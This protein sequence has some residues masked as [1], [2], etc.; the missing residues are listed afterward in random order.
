MRAG[1]RLFPSALPT[2]TALALG[3]LGLEGCAGMAQSR[4]EDAQFAALQKLLPGRYD[5]ASQVSA[6]ARAGA[7]GAHTAIDLVIVKADAAMI[8]TAVFYVRQSAANDP[9]RVLSQRIWVL[10]RAQE[11]HTK[12]PHVEQHIYVFK[13]PQ[14]WFDVTEEPELLQSLMPEDLRQ[15]SGCELLWSKVVSDKVGSG[16]AG[17]NKAGN[18]K[19]AGDFEAHRKSDSCHPASRSAGLLIEQRFELHGDRL[20]LIEQQVG[21]EGLVELSGSEVEPFYR[22]ER[23]GEN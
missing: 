10:G 8:G 18:D 7:A 14:R 6:D 5:N 20:A 1:R 12:V 9:Q 21:P 15:L 4:A 3:A 2:L 23:R 17:N 16:K 13:E 22:F 19:A 11:V